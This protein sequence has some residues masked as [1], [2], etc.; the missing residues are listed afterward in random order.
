MFQTVTALVDR[1]LLTV[2]ERLGSMR[3]GMLES[4]H[5]YARQQ[6]R[7]AG[8]SAELSGRHLSWLLGFA[9]EA[10]LEGPDQGA[11]LDLLEADL[12]N[13][14]AGLEWSMAAG[15]PELAESALQL[16]GLL[17]PFWV[18][19]G[20]IGLG[21][22]WLDAA[23]AAAGPAA[24][25]RL[26][27]IAL[28][29][30]GQLAAVHAD[31]A[32]QR[33]C[34]QESLAIWRVLGD[35]AR[36]ASCLGDLGAGAHIRGD[37]PAARA[38]YTE[39]LELA[40]GVGEV[41]QMA[42]SLSGLGR[43]ALH[44]GDLARATAYYTES[45]AR[46]GEVG[47]LRMAT[48]ILGNLGVVA[49]DQGDFPLASA[50]FDEHLGNAR[51]LGDRKLI[52]GALTNLG[53]VAHNAGDFDRAAALHADALELA[54][55]VGDRRLSS[56]A[57]TNLGLAALA[58]KEFA[59]ARAFHRRSLELA[60]AVGERRS[61]AESLTE[62]AGVD[63][64]E[65]KA[66][67]AAV[68]FS[69]AQALRAAIGSPIPGPELARFNEAVAATAAALGPQRFALAQAAGQAMPVEQAV[70]LAQQGDQADLPG[71]AEEER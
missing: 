55:Q 47:D 28:D 59:A 21:R 68:L 29:G 66:E 11:W 20:H 35:D 1:S 23:L 19:R 9:A 6:L 50:R 41:Q 52:G 37:Y 17:A 40:A 60:E 53:M 51:K 27:A 70:T 49:L 39:A 43:L 32:A 57:L 16:A 31:F 62:I 44:G 4:I 24:G 36:V 2:D 54:G 63:A 46:F 5:Q 13:F 34:Q 18:V 65:G 71:A 42:R 30:A 69:A 58:R 38:M 15:L 48:L 25:L 26:R 45:M 33:A 67:R 7:Q 12:D 22:R 56:V 10:G 3:Y 64:A 14:R 61:I 8:E